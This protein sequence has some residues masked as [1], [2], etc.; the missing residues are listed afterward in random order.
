MQEKVIDQQ[1][2]YL[3]RFIMNSIAGVVEL[4][5]NTLYGPPDEGWVCPVATP[6]QEEIEKEIEKLKEQDQKLMEKG[7]EKQKRQRQVRTEDFICKAC[8]YRVK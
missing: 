7:Q 8:D 5:Y 3:L 1:P 2:D 6:S 4:C